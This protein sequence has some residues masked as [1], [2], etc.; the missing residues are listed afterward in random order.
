MWRA[1][2]S[3]TFSVTYNDGSFSAQ[4]S[5]S[6]AGNFGEVGRER[7]G[8]FVRREEGVEG[9]EAAARPLP[10][11]TAAGLAGVQLSAVAARQTNSPLFRG[12]VPV[13]YF[14]H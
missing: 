12:K 2:N 6:S 9:A 5:F 13:E 14:F 8:S 4:G 7:N 1:T 3:G 11:K 10:G